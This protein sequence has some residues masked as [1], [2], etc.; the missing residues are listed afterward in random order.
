MQVES[1][2]KEQVEGL[3]ACACR[4]ATFYSRSRK[5][6]WCKGETSGH[7]INVLGIFPDCDRDSL[8]YLGD[9]IG[10]ACHTVRLSLWHLS[11]PAGED[12]LS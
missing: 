10:P 1:I 6:R 3:T 4:L 8:I 5:N 11:P 12:G 2:F 7:Y 9:P